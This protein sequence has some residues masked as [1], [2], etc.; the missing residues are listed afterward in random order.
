M[1]DKLFAIVFFWPWLAVL[2]MM[3]LYYLTGYVITN[4]WIISA[5][6]VLPCMIPLLLM[7]KRSK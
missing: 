7:I 2:S 1:K 6:V 4:E 5:I 3:G